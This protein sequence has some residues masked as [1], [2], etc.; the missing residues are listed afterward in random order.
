MNLKKEKKKKDS[1]DSKWRSEDE[2]ENIAKMELLGEQGS[3]EPV[4]RWNESR[5]E[6]EVRDIA[7]KVS[8]LT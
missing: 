5:C 6:D 1:V 8:Y 2:L 4:R 7:N 3:Y